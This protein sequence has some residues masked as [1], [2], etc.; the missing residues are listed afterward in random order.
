MAEGGKPSPCPWYG[1]TESPY[2]PG[3]RKAGTSHQLQT[4]VLVNRRQPGALGPPT[5][6]GTECE[7]GQGQMG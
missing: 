3:Q 5:R 7:H 4:P 6:A 1:A 2:L